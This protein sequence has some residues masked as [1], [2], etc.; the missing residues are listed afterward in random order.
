M[1]QEIIIAIIALIVAGCVGYKIW[2]YF[3][4]PAFPCDNCTGCAL[5]EQLKN[6]I[7]KHGKNR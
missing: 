5:K 1:W 6:K 2:R 3:T 4:K 7:G